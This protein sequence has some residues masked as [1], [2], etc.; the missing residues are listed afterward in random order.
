VKAYLRSRVKLFVEVNFVISG[1]LRD[2][3]RIS[4]CFPA[5][6][7]FLAKSY[8]LTSLQSPEELLLEGIS[9]MSSH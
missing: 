1:S 3:R 6:S 8:Y 4:V 5:L 2:F 9:S 7:L